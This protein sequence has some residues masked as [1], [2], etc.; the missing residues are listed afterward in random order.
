[1]HRYLCNV[2]VLKLVVK[3]VEDLGL[4]GK[5]LEVVKRSE[6]LVKLTP[7]LQEEE[8]LI[9]MS[10]DILAICCAKMVKSV[11]RG[12]RRLNYAILMVEVTVGLLVEETY[13]IT[14]AS[15]HHL[16]K[17][18]QPGPIGAYLS[19]LLPTLITRNRHNLPFI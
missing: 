6:C 17:L 11:P 3:Q 2:V 4:V 1:M 9:I 5:I 18:S 13:S 12:I 8:L 10:H 16:L 19:P 7:T 15:T 14:A